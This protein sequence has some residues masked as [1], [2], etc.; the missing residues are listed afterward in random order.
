MLLKLWKLEKYDIRVQTMLSECWMIILLKKLTRLK[1][2]GCRTIGR[3]KLRWMGGIEDGLRTLSVRGWT[4]GKGKISW[5]RPGPKLGCKAI[6][7]NVWLSFTRDTFLFSRTK[8]AL[9]KLPVCATW[10]AYLI[11]LHSITLNISGVECKL[12][13]SS[14]CN[15][16]YPHITSSLVGPDTLLSILFLNTSVSFLCFYY[17]NAL[18]HK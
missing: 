10:P 6:S 9:F 1:P 5:K 15:F 13:S 3:P 14:S 8:C 16:L 2:D 12:W 11:I 18:V 7:S 4:R 17:D